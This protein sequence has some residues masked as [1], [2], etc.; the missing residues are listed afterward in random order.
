MCRV[1]TGLAAFLS[2]RWCLWTTW[3][4]PIQPSA[5]Y[6]AEWR[7]IRMPCEA[8]QSWPLC[9]WKL[10]TSRSL[11]L[12]LTWKLP[13]QVTAHRWETYQFVAFLFISAKHFFQ[14]MFSSLLQIDMIA[15]LFQSC[16]MLE[17]FLLSDILF[18]VPAANIENSH[19]YKPL[20]VAGGGEVLLGLSS[21]RKPKYETDRPMMTM[22]TNVHYPHIIN[23]YASTCCQYRMETSSFSVNVNAWTERR[24]SVNIIQ[25]LEYPERYLFLLQ[26][27]NIDRIIECDFIHW[28]SCSDRGVSHRVTIML[29]GVMQSCLIKASVCIDSRPQLGR[30]V[31][32]CIQIWCKI[33]LSI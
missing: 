24:P 2:R 6:K 1:Q 25:R 12:Q 11:L 31:D 13:Q 9:G 29:A 22:A 5:F 30:Q 15:S 7:E 33:S 20:H 27:N 32:P 28:C 16:R 10:W 21:W 19:I 18:M 17:P 23:P 4:L 8:L 26:K 14:T 3:F